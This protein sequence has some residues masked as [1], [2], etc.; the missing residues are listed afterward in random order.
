MPKK[1][2]K[3]SVDLIAQE[4]ALAV[5]ERLDR[6]FVSFSFTRD[7]LPRRA[8][9]PRFLPYG[10]AELTAEAR[11]LREQFAKHPVL[12]RKPKDKDSA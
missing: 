2:L 3:K 9:K 5:Y 8:R 1:K 4:E 10:I 12:G 7:G 11:Q 6:M